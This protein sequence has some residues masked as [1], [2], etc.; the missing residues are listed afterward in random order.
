MKKAKSCSGHRAPGYRRTRIWTRPSLARAAG[1]VLSAWGSVLSAMLSVCAVRR[2]TCPIGAD[3]SSGADTLLRAAYA[4]HQAPHPA[5]CTA[6]AP[7]ISYLALRHR[8]RLC[9][10]G[11]DVVERIS[12]V[13]LTAG[14]SDQAPEVSGGQRFWRAGAGHVVNLLF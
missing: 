1:P 14:R 9:R 2:T 7:S 8:R 11:N 13:R 3:R 4:R 12:L 10:P 5:P 6:R